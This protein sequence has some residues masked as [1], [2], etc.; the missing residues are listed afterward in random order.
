MNN[1]TEKEPKLVS[2]VPSP[3]FEAYS[4]PI[5]TSSPIPQLLALAPSPASWTA[6]LARVPRIAASSSA[7]ALL[8]RLLLALAPLMLPTLL[9]LLKTRR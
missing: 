6:I 4:N 2:Y 9:L 3:L 1:P 5:L 8:V 7:A